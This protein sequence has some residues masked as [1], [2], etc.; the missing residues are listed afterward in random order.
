MW[1]DTNAS[2][3][4]GKYNLFGVDETKVPDLVNEEK[5]SYFGPYADKNFNKKAKIPT[6]IAGVAFVA[7]L[8]AM[9]AFGIATKSVYNSPSKAYDDEIVVKIDNENNVDLSIVSDNIRTILN[10]VKY[11]DGSADKKLSEIVVT[12]SYEFQVLE[13]DSNEEKPYVNHQYVA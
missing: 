6:I 13:Y 3:A 1:L 9:L 2:V 5:Q 10:D 7:G 11:K 12:E 8:A 4:Q